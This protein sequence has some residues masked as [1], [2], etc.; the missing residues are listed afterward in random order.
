[1]PEGPTSS[2]TVAYADTGTAGEQPITPE[3][4]DQVADQVVAM[5]LLELRIER[6]R[7]RQ[8]TPAGSAGGGRSW[9]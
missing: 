9:R 5:L 8:L 7:C 1:M 3:L 2:P 6:E 4:V